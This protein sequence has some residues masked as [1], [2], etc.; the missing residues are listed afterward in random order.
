MPRRRSRPRS[1]KLVQIDLWGKAV[2]QEPLEGSTEA[3][4]FMEMGLP[5]ALV[6]PRAMA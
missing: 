2:T 5:R 4:L 1:K 6:T 3:A